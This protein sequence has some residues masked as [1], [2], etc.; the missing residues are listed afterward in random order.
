MWKKI[1]SALNPSKPPELTTLFRVANPGQ[2]TDYERA[3]Y[4]LPVSY[5]AQFPDVPPPA[6]PTVPELIAARWVA[7]DIYAEKMPEVAADLLEA[8]FDTPSLRRLAGEW[9][10]SCRADVEELVAKMLSE[11]GVQIPA[12]EAEAKMLAT[13]QIA[14]E[15]IAG[16]KNPWKAATEL[17]SIWGYDLWH[18]EHLANI[19][20]LLDEPH[21]DAGNGRR[22]AELIAEPVENLALLGARDN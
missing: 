5:A 14:R 13:R 19:A 3:L 8:G 16:L 12:S 4:A 2:W 1:K 11:L 17:E 10:A 9:H 6:P 7:G 21:W 18:H 20:Q 22:S 15:A